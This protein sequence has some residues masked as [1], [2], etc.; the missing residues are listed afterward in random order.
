M[1]DKDKP[2]TAGAQ[3]KAKG[4]SATHVLVEASR[5]FQTAPAPVRP[6]LLM[7]VVAVVLIVIM[8][9]LPSS[10]TAIDRVL[11]LFS[12]VG[13]AGVIQLFGFLYELSSYKFALL[14]QRPDERRH[15]QQAAARF[16]SQ[17]T[18]V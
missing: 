2:K 13:A 18:N 10:Y 15:N 1:A 6:Y 14:Q 12:V 4:T 3:E 16:P 11:V 8:P 5:G 7:V 17:I 9:S